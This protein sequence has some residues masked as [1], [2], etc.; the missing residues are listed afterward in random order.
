MLKALKVRNF[1][2]IDN[3]ELDLSPHFTVITGETGAGKSILLGALSHLLGQR[4]DL[5][6]LRDKESKCV[7]EGDFVL[8]PDKFESLFDRLNLDFD[9]LTIIRREILPSGKSRAFV[10]DS[11]VRL[12]QLSQLSAT[13]ID[14]HSQHDTV[15]L[16]DSSYQL[17]LVDA[18]GLDS[19]VF[20]SYQ[21]AYTAWMD[22]KNKYETLKAEESQEGGDRDY[23]QFLFEELVNAQLIP[24]EQ[25]ELETQLDRLEH[26][27]TIEEKLQTFLSLSDQEPQGISESLRTLKFSLNQIAEFDPQLKILSERI[28]SLQIEFEDLRSEVESYSQEGSFDPREKDRLDQRLSQLIQL[29]KKHQLSSVEDLIAK[30]A[31]LELKILKADGREEALKTLGEQITS[32]ESI[33]EQ[34][35]IALKAAREQIIPGLIAEIQS[36]LKDL[37]ME[38]AQFDLK[39]MDSGD[40]SQRGRDRLEF[41]FTANPGMPLAP[42]N[43]IAS[44]GEMSRL[45][46]ALKAILSKSKSLNTIVFD[47]IDTGVSGETALKI[48]RILAAMGKNM[49]VLSISHLA[50][51]ASKAAQHLK[52]EKHTTN[53]HTRTTLIE[54]DPFQRE[55]EIARLLSGDQPSEEAIANARALLKA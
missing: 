44:G 46:L 23:L 26:A 7:I 13:L 15:L 30:Q 47:E 31:D 41:L 16:N 8:D 50:Q 43:K 4:A 49:Q 42:L 37:N 1:A 45:M 2:L 48:A 24:N 52:V 21:L 12:D 18:Y 40:Y 55:Q 33:L 6:A 29:Q 27:G 3:L 25:S 34:E 28:D 9:P 51:I 53:D 11:P 17:E 39:L 38:S 5:K 54:L 22:L 20:E 35:A 32:A 36:I 14:V 19:R 10:N